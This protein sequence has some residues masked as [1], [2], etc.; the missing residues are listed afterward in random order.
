LRRADQPIGAAFLFNAE[1]RRKGM[2]ATVEVYLE[3]DPLDHRPNG[4]TVTKAVRAAIREAGVAVRVTRCVSVVDLPTRAAEEL[5]RAI[6][7][8]M[9]C[10]FDGS[11]VAL[12]GEAD[13]DWGRIEDSLRGWRRIAW[14]VPPDLFADGR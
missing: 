4:A 6:P 3:T 7:D 10:A 5:R 14:R 12:R 9:A 1:L 13:Q 11:I 8:G 2:E